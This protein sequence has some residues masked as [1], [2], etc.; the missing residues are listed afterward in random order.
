MDNSDEVP[1]PLALPVS[2]EVLELPDDPDDQV[3]I[4]TVA[5]VLIELTASQTE[6]LTASQTEQPEQQ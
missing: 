1:S 2:P 4:T 3:E 6:Q 5:K